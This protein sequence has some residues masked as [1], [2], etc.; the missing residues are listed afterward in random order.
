MTIATNPAGGG[1]APNNPP[2]GAGG[3]P[4]A[5]AGGGDPPAGSSQKPGSSAGDG[6]K[7]GAA[8][9]GEDLAALR[10]KVAEL[11]ADKAA[12]DKAAG[13][14]A[15]KAEQ[16]RQAGLSEA[17]KLQEKVAALESAQAADKAELRRTKLD[18]AADRLGVKANYRQYLP[19]VDP[20]D[21]AG[22]AK[23][24]SWAKEHPEAIAPRGG[25]PQPQPSLGSKLLDIVQGK[26]SSPLVTDGLLKKW[27]IK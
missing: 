11:E 19:D 2:A 20:S 27:G 17:Q 13:E 22:Q 14:A 23:L 4:A 3:S 1:G 10:A 24:E 5:G 7:P 12:R 21:P 16:E 6:Q 26:V 18:A 9:G 25:E 8:S 15:A